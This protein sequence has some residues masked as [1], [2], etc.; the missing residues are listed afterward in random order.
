[1]NVTTISIKHSIE[2]VIK[3]DHVVRDK[4]QNTQVMSRISSYYQAYEYE[5][6][7]TSSESPLC[8]DKDRP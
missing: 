8:L 6:D 1:M 2:N 3:A 4:F 5:A 7:L